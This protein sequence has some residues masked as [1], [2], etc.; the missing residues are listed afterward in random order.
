MR[1]V[2]GTLFSGVDARMEKQKKTVEITEEQKDALYAGLLHV[3]GGFEKRLA[4]KLPISYQ[5]TKPGEV[6]SYKN[7]LIPEA[8]EYAGLSMDLESVPKGMSKFTHWDRVRDLLQNGII[9]KIKKDQGKNKTFLLFVRPR[10]EA[11]GITKFAM[12]LEG[13]WVKEADVK[14]IDAPEDLE[15]IFPFE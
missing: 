13:I 3:G 14:Q 1:S 11:L 2:G 7:D 9:D 15:D 8:T 12:R 5:Y 4:S 10:I 6:P